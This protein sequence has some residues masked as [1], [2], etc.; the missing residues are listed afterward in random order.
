MSP[1]FRAICLETGCTFEAIAE[2][3]FDVDFDAQTHVIFTG[4]RVTDTQE[5]EEPPC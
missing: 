3:A 5:T 2:D 1:H 4:H